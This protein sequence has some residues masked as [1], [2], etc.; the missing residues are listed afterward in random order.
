MQGHNTRKPEPLTR[1][2]NQIFVSISAGL[3]FPL[4]DK[5]CKKE[6]EKKKSTC[7]LNQSFVHFH[8]GLNKKVYT[9][10]KDL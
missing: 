6:F 2:I 1:T 3:P 8:L 10:E 9:I 5:L 4:L 7:S